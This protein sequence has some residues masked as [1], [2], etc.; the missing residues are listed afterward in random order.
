MAMDQRNPDY[1]NGKPI[2]R[3]DAAPVL[4]PEES[5]QGIMT[6]HIRWILAVSVALAIVA[7]VVMLAIYV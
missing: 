5:R 1:R 4:T 3:H 6:G 2:A 7:L